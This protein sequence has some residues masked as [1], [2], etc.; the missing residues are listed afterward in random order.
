MR[1]VWIS[2]LV[3]LIDQLTKYAVVQTMW[4]GSSVRLIGDWFKFTYTTNPGMAFGIEVG[5]QGLVGVFSVIAT[6]LIVA[7]LWQVRTGYRPYVLSLAFILGG[8]LGN[9][10][11][12]LFYG[13]WQGT[14]GLFTGE[15]VDFIHFDIWRGTL[16]EL[17]PFLGGDPIYF[18]F[19]PIWN[20][21]DMAIVAGVVGVLVFQRRFHET[22]LHPRAPE[23]DGEAGAAVVDVDGLPDGH[24]D[25]AD[26]PTF[27]GPVA[28]VAEPVAP[29][30][31]APPRGDGYPDEREAPLRDGSQA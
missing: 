21:A 29:A 15:V 22:P 8:A 19:F 27:V 13:Y 1:V 5:P 9:I 2:A 25:G 16:Q 14:G 17:I 18:A 24:P 4:L 11:D 7:Y 31:V 26:A 6:G 30:P 12:R 20:V 23:A 10:I 3:V 28:P